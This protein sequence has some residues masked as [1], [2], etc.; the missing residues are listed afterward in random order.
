MFGGANRAQCVLAPSLHFATSTTMT[1][2][3]GWGDPPQQR[4]GRVAPIRSRYLTQVMVM[5][6]VNVH[7]ALVTDA[8]M[9]PKA[10]PMSR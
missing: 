1:R 10:N 4:G 6:A 2:A 5:V 3:K 8:G 7:A 9:S